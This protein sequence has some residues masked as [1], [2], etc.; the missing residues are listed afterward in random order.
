[1]TPAPVA[2]RRGCADPL[3]QIC[4]HYVTTKA[5]GPLHPQNGPS[6]G[7]GAGGARVGGAALNRCWAG[8]KG[9]E[10]QQKFSPGSHQAAAGVRGGLSSNKKGRPA[11]RALSWAGRTCVTSHR[12][13]SPIHPL[14]RPSSERCHKYVARLA[15]VGVCVRSRKNRRPPCKLGP[16]CQNSAA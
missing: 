7:E 1:M 4:S 9:L 3:P 15:K 12:N 11:H 2:V 5:E 14:S 8:G 10:H 6:G 16:V 13:S